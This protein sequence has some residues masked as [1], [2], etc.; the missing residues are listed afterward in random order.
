V[1]PKPPTSEREKEFRRRLGTT[2]FVAADPHAL[3]VAVVDEAA[4]LFSEMEGEE[5][6]RHKA[7]MFGLFRML[8]GEQISASSGIDG[9]NTY[10]YGK[11]DEHGFWEFPVPENF[12]DRFAAFRRTLTERESGAVSEWREIS[13][14]PKDGTRILVYEPG[15]QVSIVWW[16]KNTTYEAGGYWTPGAIYRHEPTLWMPLP[17]PPAS[18]ASGEGE[19]TR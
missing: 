5:A 14:A 18:P 1:T 7:V 10:G 16:R 17:S 13:T 8:G 11:L 19:G 3:M 6:A 2:T 4:R 15:E 12:Y 9:S